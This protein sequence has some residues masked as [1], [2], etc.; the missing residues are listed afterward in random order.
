SS[1]FINNTEILQKN[2]NP[3][4]WGYNS[5]LYQ[6]FYETKLTKQNTFHINFQSTLLG[7]SVIKDILNYSRFFNSAFPNGDSLLV[8]NGTTRQESA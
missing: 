3:K 7:N 4:K 5:L 6:V 8:T 1:Y 2:Y